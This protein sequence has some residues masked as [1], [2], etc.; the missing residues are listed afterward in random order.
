MNL[1]L[2]VLRLL[3]VK[4]LR[5][6]TWA[7][8]R[9]YDSP[10][11]PADLRLPKERAPYIAVYVDDGDV[12]SLRENEIGGGS[13]Y[14]DGEALLIVEVSVA[15]QAED[16]PAINPDDDADPTDPDIDR[17]LADPHTLALTD[18]ALE[19]RIGLIAAQAC[20]ALS[21]PDNPWAELWRTLAPDR[22]S[23]EIRRGGSGQDNREEEAYRYA[24]RHMRLRVGL[25][26][27]PAPGEGHGRVP[28]F[29]KDCLEAMEADEQ[30]R[31]IAALLRL[32]LDG[33]LPEQGW[34][35]AQ[36]QG[37][38]TEAAVRGIGIGPALRGMEETPYVE[39][40]DGVTS[41]GQTGPIED[42]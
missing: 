37:T 22:I 29:W 3:T 19:L 31:G 30:Y 35:K 36:R 27:E 11:E 39:N 24:T 2:D 4:A 9:V 1:T 14:A 12:K 10:A 25:M 23:L 8:L 15:G 16:N 38:L 17:Q 40:G 5:G 41:Q 21:E 33:G 7:G 32:H 6:R 13:L 26:Q 28:G 20:H 34:R 18:P 42:E